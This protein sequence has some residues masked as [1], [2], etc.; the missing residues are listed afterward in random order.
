MFSMINPHREIKGMFTSDKSSELGVGL[1]RGCASK[2]VRGFIEASALAL[3]SSTYG[4]QLQ[5]VTL[6][7]QILYHS[8]LFRQASRRMQ[9]PF[10]LLEIV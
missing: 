4:L 8:A 7:G 6:H 9:G 2:R 3:F 10:N 5:N 1:Y